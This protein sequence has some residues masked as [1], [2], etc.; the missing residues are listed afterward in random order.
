MLQLDS[1]C[2]GLGKRLF[3]PFSV[4][5]A[6]GE[7]VAIL[8]PSGAGKSTLL[9]LMSR[10]YQASTGQV[11]LNNRPYRGWRTAELGGWRAVLPQSNQVAFGL[12]V[13]LVIGLGRVARHPDPQL[14]D[15]VLAA[16]RLAHAD[17][18]LG[19]RFDQLS[20]GEQSRVQL[21]RVFAQLWDCQG[22]MVLL[23]EP[24]AAL[25]PGLQFEL[26]D[27]IQTFA[28]DRQHAVVA[29]VHDINQALGS[30]DR[31]LLV[32]EGKTCADVRVG[33][34]AIP[35]LADLY[36]IDL[37]VVDD[38]HGGLAVMPRRKYER[39]RTGH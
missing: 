37:Q 25:D 22:G 4:R 18:L 29:V 5:V 33:P 13:D 21:A 31:L 9:K 36:G 26:M 24:L 35:P 23:D 11:S 20:G 12:Q 32:K 38:G 7:W 34:D 10:E 14:N 6:P 1:A 8:G 16:A 19:R 28:V 2:I 3:G 27:A 15:V 17:H 30:F 39:Q